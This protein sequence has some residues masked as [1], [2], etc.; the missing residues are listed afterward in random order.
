MAVRALGGR[1]DTESDSG[2]P[3]C[4]RVKTRRIETQNGRV[5]LTQTGAVWSR[6]PGARRIPRERHTHRCRESP[7]R[8]QL[9][10]SSHSQGF[11]ASDVPMSAPVQDRRLAAL[12]RF[13]HAVWG[14]RDIFTERV[15]R[16]SGPN[17]R[18][19][20]YLDFREHR[21]AVRYICNGMRED[22]LLVVQE[23]RDAMNNFRID[24]Q[25]YYDRGACILGQPGIGKMH[26]TWLG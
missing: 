3:K 21:D 25:M 14:N 20:E 18:I 7:G 24:S 1:V 19:V 4:R 12:E 10:S 6:M 22:K 2:P 13:R 26:H 9:D 8:W 17:P 16:Q 23:Y 5:D 11:K 15:T